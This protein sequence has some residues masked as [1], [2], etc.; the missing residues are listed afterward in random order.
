MKNAL[1]NVRSIRFLILAVNIVGELEVLSVLLIEL[2][3]ALGNS[4][5]VLDV[6]RNILKFS[7]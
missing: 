3:R 7:C 4:L 6:Y 2:P 1:K 5:S